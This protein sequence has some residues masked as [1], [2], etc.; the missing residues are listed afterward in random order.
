MISGRMV[1]VIHVYISIAAVVLD[2]GKR[3]IQQAVSTGCILAGQILLHGEYLHF[4]VR[5]CSGNCLL[6]SGFAYPFFQLDISGTAWKLQTTVQKI[7]T[8][9][10]DFHT[11]VSRAN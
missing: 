5:S 11:A 9:G 7:T 3:F 2:I 6:P 4:C 8:P 1:S 10:Y